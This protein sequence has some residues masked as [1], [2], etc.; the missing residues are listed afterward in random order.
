MELNNSMD[1]MKTFF[2]NHMKRIR[3]PATNIPIMDC[4]NIVV[5]DTDFSIPKDFKIPAGVHHSQNMS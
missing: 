3:M 1:L 5:P 2:D 4:I